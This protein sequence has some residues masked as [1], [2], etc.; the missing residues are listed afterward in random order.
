MKERGHPRPVLGLLVDPSSGACIWA[1]GAIDDDS[2]G[3]E[4]SIIC[5]P[6]HTLKEGGGRYGISYIVGFDTIIF[7]SGLVIPF[8]AKDF[9]K[10]CRQ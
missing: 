3:R 8:I 10:E 7:H 9:D 4:V 5:V 6:G 2:H 1:G